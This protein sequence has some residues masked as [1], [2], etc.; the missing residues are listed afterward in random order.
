MTPF[1]YSIQL[2][3]DISEARAMMDEHD[4]EHL[5]VV[6]GT[7]LVGLLTGRDIHVARELEAHVPNR[8][9][10]VF[11]LYQPDPYVVDFGERLDIVVR[12]MS[13]RACDC[14]LVLHL[15]KLSGIITGTDVCRLLAESLRAQYHVPTDDGDAA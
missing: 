11:R 3:A 10:A 13:R 12:E 14:A 2:T 5:P 4:I 7:A 15:G 1:P 6:D 8:G 9:I